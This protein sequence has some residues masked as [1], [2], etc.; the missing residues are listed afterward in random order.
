[1]PVRAVFF[2]LDDTLLET[3]YSHEAAL[4][5]ACEHAAVLFP[6]WTAAA[7]R[8]AFQQGYRR[9]ERDLELGCLPRTSQSMFRTVVW[10]QVLEDCRLDP[11]PARVLAEI[12]LSERRSS[13]ALYDDVPDTLERLRR[14][15]ALVL[16]T[17]GLTDIQREK[18]DA[19]G[20]QRWISNLAISSEIGSWKPHAGIFQHALAVAGVEAEHAVMEGDSL[21]RDVVGA[22]QAGIR[23]VWIRRHPNLTPMQDVRP[24]AEVE[25]MHG[26]RSV[27][28]R[29]A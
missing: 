3:Y 29:W 14:R 13:Y 4:K 18:V 27:L 12:Y 10:E 6:N 2:D 5:R 23:A 21:P 15:Y 8:D 22:Q 9:L 7:L 28:D 16:V 20:L 11:E 24:D 26:L 19:V 17:N 25:D 1:M